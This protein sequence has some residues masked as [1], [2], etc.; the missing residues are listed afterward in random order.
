MIGAAGPE[1][2]KLTQEETKEAIQLQAST[3][4]NLSIC[5]FKM[6]EFR[7]SL[8]RATES[9]TL[10]QSEKALYRRAQA[11]AA[12]KDYWKAVADLKAAIK[13]NP[14]DPNNFAQELARFEQLA[15]AKDKASD[16]KLKGFLLQSRE[17]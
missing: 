11:Y 13:L 1:E 16:K 7:K 12:L 2:G 8:D 5:Y 6:Q 4:L 3:F 10:K 15:Q 9:L 14:S 17:V